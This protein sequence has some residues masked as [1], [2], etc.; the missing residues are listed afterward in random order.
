[1]S[2]TFKGRERQVKWQI[3]PHADAT[4]IHFGDTGQVCLLKSETVASFSDTGRACFVRLKFEWPTVQSGV[5][6]SHHHYE[7][8]WLGGAVRGYTKEAISPATTTRRIPIVATKLDKPEDLHGLQHPY[9][10]DVFEGE[11]K[12]TDLKERFYFPGLPLEVASL[13]SEMAQLEWLADC[14]GDLLQ[15][16]RQQIRALAEARQNEQVQKFPPCN[17]AKDYGQPNFDHYANQ[18]EVLLKLLRKKWHRLTNA[19]VELKNAKTEQE[20]SDRQTKIWLA[21][22]ADYKS[23]FRKLPDINEKDFAELRNNDKWHDHYIRLMSDAINNIPQ[24]DKRDWQLA[25]GWIGKN[26]YRMNE[27]ELETAFA[28]DWNYKSCL[29]KGNTLAKRAHRLGLVSYLTPGP[30]K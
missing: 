29:Y 15:R 18:R 24:G 19:T 5:S 13:K 10:V 16:E 14:V 2:E 27:S 4:K 3:I 26:Y 20:K 21:Y 30:K 1:M 25:I 6:K 23:L 11:T 7:L 9:R 12:L 22:I 8:T 17:P 28:R